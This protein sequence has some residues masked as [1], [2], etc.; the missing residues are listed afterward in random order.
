MLLLCLFVVDQALATRDLLADG[1]GIPGSTAFNFM[2]LGYRVEDIWNDTEPTVDRS[3]S[4]L[5]AESAV[6]GKYQLKCE[7]FVMLISFCRFGKSNGLTRL[8]G[9]PALLTL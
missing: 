2:E 3:E 5:C 1:R 6:I 8:G 4:V 9:L 7:A